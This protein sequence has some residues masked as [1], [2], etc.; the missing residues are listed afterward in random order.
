ML[1]RFVLASVLCAAFG[2][3]HA[4][5]PAPVAQMLAQ[6]GLPEDALGVLVLKGDSVLLSHGADRPMQPA[7]TMKLVTTLVS[8]ERLGPAFRA[9]TE[10]RTS[11]QVDGSVLRGDLFLKGGADADFSGEALETMLR[12][13]RYRGISR[14]EGKL[15]L[16]RSLWQPARMDLGQPPFDESPEAYYNVI[17]DALLVNKN[18]LQID[19]RSTAKR[20]QLQMQPA[21]DRVSIGSSMTLVDA[22][23]ARWEDG[24]KLPEAVRQQ[25]GRIKVLLHGTFPKDCARSY[26]INVLDRDDYLERLFRQ[27]W[28]ELGGKFSG[29]VVAGNTPADSTL[30]AEHSS[31]LLPELVRDTN[32]PSDNLLARTLFLSLGSLAPEG[33]AT[34]AVPTVEG[35]TSFARADAAVRAWMR[36]QRID[37]AGFVI[38]NGSGLSRLERITPQQMAY[39]LQAGLRSP[40]MPEFLASMPIAGIDGTLR[41]RLQGSPAAGRARLK[42]GTLRNVVALAGYVPDANGVQNVFV[43][44][45]NSEQAGNGR[46][47]AVLDALVD[48]VARSGAAPGAEVLPAPA[49]PVLPEAAAAGR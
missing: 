47:R 1:R 45:V 48:W 14:I 39:L 4:Q 22:D 25:D 20:L 13:L 36:A 17:P 28:K 7:S 31:R 2:A 18:M 34:S 6:Q 24:W 12:A 15:V 27:Q 11:G 40:W 8:L 43:A 44:M 42:T 49:M 30:L 21:L 9:R 32:K 19:L 29:T 16:D 38:E 26:S 10:L 33:A 5:L 37:D 23:C 46:G 3:A 35:E 41:R